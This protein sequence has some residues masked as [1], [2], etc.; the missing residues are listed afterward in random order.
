[1]GFQ[2]YTNF[3]GYPSYDSPVIPSFQSPPVIATP[4]QYVVNAPLANNMAPV[5]PQSKEEKA[6]TRRVFSNEMTAATQ[7][8]TQGIV[9][10]PVTE[11]L[12]YNATEQSSVSYDESEEN[13]YNNHSQNDNVQG[14]FTARNV[15]TSFTPN[16]FG[17]VNGSLKNQTGAGEKLSNKSVQ[18]EDL[19]GV[20]SEEDNFSPTT[21]PSSKKPYFP[22]ESHKGYVTNGTGTEENFYNN[23]ASN[24]GVF[25]GRGELS[26]SSTPSMHQAYS[27]KESNDNYKPNSQ[28]NETEIDE[29]FYNHSS[30]NESLSGLFSGKADSSSSITHS[31]HQ[32]D[33]PKESKER[34]AINSRQSEEGNGKAVYNNQSANNEGAKVDFRFKNIPSVKNQFIGQANK[35]A[36]GTDSVKEV[37]AADSLQTGNHTFE[38][39]DYKDEIE[40]EA[41]EHHEKQADEK[42]EEPERLQMGDN[43]DH[44]V[45]NE[46]SDGTDNLE[47]RQHSKEMLLKQNITDLNP[48]Y[49]SFAVSPTVHPGM[50]PPCRK[51]FQRQP[52]HA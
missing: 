50:C 28:K 24:K 21:T 39:H 42:V 8:R 5:K 18:K 6:S 31:F 45:V 7:P 2:G 20:F 37:N 32:P 43:N 10:D 47:N 9:S 22:I 38:G 23:S 19:N 40:K 52:V 29:K 4:L 15:S 3:P 36:Y 49:H 51:Y 25:S 1:M 17:K 46:H 16:F 30:L 13:S 44:S 26:S 12:K 27:Q 41:G 34:Y 48:A 14:I 35:T 33:S 11:P